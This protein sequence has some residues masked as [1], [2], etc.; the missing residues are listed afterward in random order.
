MLLVIRESLN[1]NDVYIDF[2]LD[3]G[4]APHANVDYDTLE[5]AKAAYP[6]VEWSEPDEDCDGTVL[7]WG[8]E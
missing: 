3:E 7:A 5:A 4:S 1:G 6:G 2:C 8:W